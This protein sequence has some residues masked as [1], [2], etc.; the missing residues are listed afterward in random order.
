LASTIRTRVLGISASASARLTAVTV[1]PSPAIALVTTTVRGAFSGL[2]ATIELRSVR[3][4]SA[5]GPR[6]SATSTTCSLAIVSLRP[7]SGSATCR[8]PLGAVRLES[9]MGK[10]DAPGN[11][12]A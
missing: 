2:S 12:P 10:G 3:Y 1:L 8:G 4:C 5:I 9:F 7:S 11:V 6:G